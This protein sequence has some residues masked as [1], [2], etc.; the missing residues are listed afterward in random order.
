MVLYALGGRAAEGRGRTNERLGEAAGKY[1]SRARCRRVGRSSS[2]P[3][4][5]SSSL[6]SSPSQ[7]SPLL[8]HSS[9]SSAANIVATDGGRPL[10]LVVRG[11][12][13]APFMV[14]ATEHMLAA[15]EK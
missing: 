3:S 9:S 12:P 10:T 7:M 13:E 4:S 11:F 14:D 1:A 8:S 6:L 15:F 2:S 5:P